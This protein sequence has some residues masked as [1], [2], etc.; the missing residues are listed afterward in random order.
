MPSIQSAET[1][2]ANADLLRRLAAAIALA[3]EP[4]AEVCE[5]I[6][7]DI[8]AE[9]ASHW[10]IGRRRSTAWCG[11]TPRQKSR[12]R[13]ESGLSKGSDAMPNPLFLPLLR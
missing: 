13:A 4:L 5:R 1:I 7:L 6:A 9:A 3:G 2:R 12:S 11:A 10:G 8:R